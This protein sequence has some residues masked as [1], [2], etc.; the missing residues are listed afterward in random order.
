MTSET[1]LERE[2]IER[3]FLGSTL[4]RKKPTSRETAK[5]RQKVIV[6]AGPTA[7]GKSDFAIELAKKLGGEIV[8][9]DSMQIYRGMDIGTA[10]VPLELREKIPHHLVDVRDVDESFSVVD[11]YYEGRKAIQ[12]ILA[13]DRV[14]IVVGGTGFYIHTAIYGPPSGPPSVAELRHY[15]E[16]EL[17]RVGIQAMFSKLEELDPAYAATITKNDKQ[18]VVRA[19]EIIRLTGEKVSSLSWKDRR[20]PSDYDFRC[21]FLYRPKEFL[22]R[23]I[24][25]RCEE[26]IAEGFIE[27][28][29]SLVARGI[30]CNSSASQAIGYRQ[31]LDFLNGS[32]SDEEFADFI[33]KFK[34]VSRK[35][36]KRQFTWFRR[37]P[38]FRWL[39]LLLHDHEVAMEMVLQDYCLRL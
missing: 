16:K 9:A 34:Q 25:E 6:I 1:K 13:R 14:P 22:Y 4:E 36:A 26:M 31:A 11:F 2:E 33:N 3:M 10:K 24:N 38:I 30:L 28:V 7:V 27:E 15:L 8:S 21:W 12:Q 37:E 23:R 32:G 17:E 35:Y 29:R 39:D 18:K 20:H 19:L 5:P